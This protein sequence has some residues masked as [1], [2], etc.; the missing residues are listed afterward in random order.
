MQSWS[1]RKKN[2][3]RGRILPRRPD[4]SLQVH[5]T[6]CLQSWLC[7]YTFQ[8]IF[9]VSV[10]LASRRKAP[11]RPAAGLCSKAPRKAQGPWQPFP[12]PPSS[13]G[14]LCA[15][16]GFLHWWKEQEHFASNDWHLYKLYEHFPC[17]QRILYT[18]LEVGRCM[19][20]CCKWQCDRTTNQ[21]KEGNELLLILN[22]S[23]VLYKVS[24]LALYFVC[25]GGF[26]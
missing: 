18:A 13:Y 22:F 17:L 4:R 23:A 5:H 10:P 3:V 1:I 16:L 6:P 14:R 26:C 15:A 24:K 7:H 12:L 25:Y 2:E 8:L 19:C 21:L 11:L 20:R 9:H